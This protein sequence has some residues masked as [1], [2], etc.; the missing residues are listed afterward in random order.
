MASSWAFAR[1]S[2]QSTILFLIVSNRFTSTSNTVLVKK[3][4][5][6]RIR[7]I[8]IRQFRSIQ[9]FDWF[10]APGVNCLLGPGDTGKSTVLDA[11]DLCLSPR[12]TATFTDTDFYKL[13][14][15]TPIQI[16]ITLG[17][18]DDTLKNLDTY[19][20]YLR[21]FIAE[22]SE[23]LPEPEAGAETVL[24]LQMTVT[25]DLEPVWSLYSER[26]VAQNQTR[27]LNWA[28]RI[29]LAPTR[30]GAF[31]D[32]NLGWRRGSV[33]NR[34]SDE[35]ADASA[36]LAKA[37]REA[38][39]TF[40]ESAKGQVSETLAIVK[41]TADDLGI[42]VGDVTAMLDAHSVSFSGG[43]ISLHDGDGVPLRELG[44]GSVR[45]LIGGLQRQ[46]AIHSAIILVDEVEHGLEP[47]RI[48]RLLTS[49]GAKEITPPLQVFLTT[50]SPVALRELSADQLYVLRRSATNLEIRHVGSHTDMQSTVR[51][52]PEAFLAPSVIVCEGA[53]EI[54]LARGLDLHR[55]DDGKLSM[56]ALGIAVADG[57]GDTTFRRANAFLALGYRTLIV[58]DDDKEPDAT[59][60]ATFKAGG[61]IV[62]AWRSGRALEE[63]LF[64]SLTDTAI[65]KL[66]EAAIEN[67]GE[68]RVDEHIKSASNNDLNLAACRAAVT[69][70]TREVLG[71]A[72][73]SKKSSW[74]KSVTVMETIGREIVGP[75]LAGADAGFRVSVETLF[76]WVSNGSR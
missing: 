27:N 10:P 18:L 29:K 17:E 32:Q 58:R 55:I 36:E 59:E 65:Q 62:I 5:M 11:I 63:E 71:K 74:F 56:M 66:I 70:T 64:A 68:D 54:G 73:K 6:S 49:L 60:A 26:A 13:D 48:I 38:R 35:R 30:V 39:K 52:C 61:G 28:D 2:F 12:R 9:A 24:T 33:L 53:S 19:G 31:A 20:L 1:S 67:V 76:A 7:R 16:S 15:A 34:V 43:T 44:L 23:I 4:T 21:G 69:V 47:H 8:E 40:G 45:L 72:S 46:A 37:T 41:R 3:F 22:K 50:H 57:H 51:A 42:P 75:D 25:G 14:V